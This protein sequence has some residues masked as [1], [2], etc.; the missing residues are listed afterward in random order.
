LVKGDKPALAESAKTT[1]NL[2]EAQAIVSKLQITSLDG[3]VMFSTPDGFSGKTNKSLVAQAI[4]ERVIT[5]GL[6][7]DDDGRL[8]AVV[9]FPL[10]KRGQPVGAGVF[11]RDLGDAIADFKANDESEVIIVDGQGKE[12]YTTSEGLFGVLGVALPALGDSN[13]AVSKHD[14]VVESVAMLPVTN[15]RGEAVA[16]LVSVKDFTDSYV[17]QGRFN[18]IAYAVIAAVLILSILGLYWYMQRS[19]RPLQGAA[20]MLREI[21]DGNLGQQIEVT[22]K[23]EIGQLQ[24][25]MASMVAQL[26]DMLKSINGM[27]DKLTTSSSNLN[28][29]ADEMNQ[30]VT[31]QQSQ[32]DQVATAMNEMTATVQEVARHAEDAAQA[33][34]NAD[35]QAQAGSG[36][37]R[38]TVEAINQL[39][40]EVEN[41]SGVI[42]KLESDSENIGAVLDVI[43]GIAEQ[44]NLLALNAAIEAARAGEQGRGFAVVADE[45]RTL[46]SRTQKSTEEIEAMIA[47]LQQG[48]QN[49]VAVMATS[50]DRA[51]AGVEHAAKAGETLSAI[52]E[53]VATITTMNHQIAT[54]AN[55]QSAV[56]EEINRSIVGISEVG[57]LT[58]TS[59]AQTA[60]ST[61]ELNGLASELSS[62]VSR[63]RL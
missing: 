30:G 4:D 49:A 6:E 47:Q 7:R 27:T 61:G 1:F 21:A 31:Q 55:E 62:L 2:L 26:H 12:L 35:D 56:A 9:A 19:L 46:A 14:D 58:A 8:M 42:A 39:A 11:M 17:A 10:L 3:E 13:V 18:A 51:K 50:R 44:T 63:F 59:A 23:D 52:T 40:G 32:T 25:A 54:A 28:R 5:Q 20:E 38:N 53:A 24:G 48:A 43:K 45:V 22:S 16:H 36:V 15:A 34:A 37:V 33:A 29:V 41:A 57:E 60:S